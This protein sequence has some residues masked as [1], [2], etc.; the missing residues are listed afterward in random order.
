MLQKGEIKEQLH[1]CKIPEEAA[2]I[3]EKYE[4]DILE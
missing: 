3:I 2:L 1:N 4:Y